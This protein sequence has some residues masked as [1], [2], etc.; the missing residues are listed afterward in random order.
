[1]AAVDEAVKAKAPTE[2]EI[3]PLVE[4]AAEAL[5]LPPQVGD[6]ADPW[7]EDRSVFQISSH[8]LERCCV[9]GDKS[10][11]IYP[12]CRKHMI[13]SDAE[14]K[15]KER[16]LAVARGCRDYGGGHHTDGKMDA[17]QHGIET[18]ITALT[19]FYKDPTDTQTRALEAIGEKVKS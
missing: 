8:L 4:R 16:M 13:N 6:H 15:L 12:V 1:M 14:A 5:A 11:R 19:A 3:E 10:Y 18:V 17:F 2:S 9:C 7:P